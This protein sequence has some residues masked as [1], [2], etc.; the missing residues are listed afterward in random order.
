[1]DAQ[2]SARANLAARW[3]PTRSLGLSVVVVSVT[4]LGTHDKTRTK[5][6]VLVP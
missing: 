6:M 3:S 1:V 2:V 5:P 4:V